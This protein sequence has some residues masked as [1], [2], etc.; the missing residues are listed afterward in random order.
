MPPPTAS[1]SGPPLPPR[2]R[3]PSRSLLLLPSSH[4]ILSSPSHSAFRGNPECSPDPRRW[5]G[6]RVWFSEPQGASVSPL[7]RCHRSTGERGGESQKP[8]S[9]WK[10][11]PDGAA[12]KTPRTLYRHTWETSFPLHPLWASEIRKTDN[13]LPGMRNKSLIFKSQSGRRRPSGGF[14]KKRSR[15][16]QIGPAPADAGPQLGTLISEEGKESRG[17]RPPAWGAHAGLRYVNPLL[18]SLQR[19]PEPR[20]RTLTPLSDVTRFLPHK[21]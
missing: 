6:V 7:V 5:E 12:G 16:N 19:Q 8:R 4:S 20:E 14:E 1:R 3:S 9:A 15:Q 17:G 11:S 10:G 13:P 2:G 18:R 21:H